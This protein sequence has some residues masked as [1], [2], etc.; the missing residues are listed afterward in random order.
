VEAYEAQAEVFREQI[1]RFTVQGNGAD[2]VVDQDRLLADLRALQ[3]DEPEGKQASA[4]TTAT[5]RPHTDGN[6]PPA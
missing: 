1:R 2:L 5:S 6:D 4:M 3:G